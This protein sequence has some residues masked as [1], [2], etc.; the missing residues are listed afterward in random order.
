M[1]RRHFLALAALGPMFGHWLSGA[2]HAASAF[3]RRADWGAKSPTKAMK[4][5]TPQRITLHHTAA[6][7]KLN[8]ATAD[9]LRS[10]QRFSQASEKLADGRMKKAWA[11][12]P[13]HFYVTANGDIA[14][15][16]DPKF[17]GDTNTNYDPTGHVAIA[18]E[19]NFEVEQP[20]TAQISA[21]TGLI[22]LLMAR[23]SIG[24]NK[25]GLHGDYAS[26][27]CPGKAFRTLW[28]SLKA[29]LG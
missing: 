6:R 16:R 22:Q 1:R 19:G 5:H 29:K 3:V 21:L 27:A 13:Y 8:T 4:K 20:T 25:V 24:A 17:V 15:G 23:Y 11:D 9:K 2:A 26:T 18:I 7:Q 14:E 10:L 12:V 28:P